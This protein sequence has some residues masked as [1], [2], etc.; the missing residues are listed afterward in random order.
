MVLKATTRHDVG[1]MAYLGAHL[2]LQGEGQDE[3]A[4]QVHRCQMSR[5]SCTQPHARTHAR[6]NIASDHARSMNR[7]TGK[8]VFPQRHE[9]RSCQQRIFPSI[10]YEIKYF[11]LNV[12]VYG[13]CSPASSPP[14]DCMGAPIMSGNKFT[15]VIREIYYC[16]CIA[17]EMHSR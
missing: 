11:F 10:Y 16:Y 12:L 7:I 15:G 5:S 3:D 4:D 14:G 8:I 17:H 6:T 13:I 1:C 9:T 2:M